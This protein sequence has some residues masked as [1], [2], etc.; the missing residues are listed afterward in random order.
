MRKADLEKLFQEN[1][2]RSLSD[3]IYEV[4]LKDIIEFHL[5]PGTKI[6]ETQLAE[7]L[8]VSKTPLRKALDQLER[9]GHVVK[10]YNKGTFVS[11]LSVSDYFDIIDFRYMIEPMAAGFASQC[12][13]EK[14]LKQLLVYTQNIEHV[15]SQR[16]NSA[17]LEAEDNFHKYIVLCSK[18]KYLID[19]YE[20]IETKIKKYRMYI[21]ADRYLHE[22]LI[23]I[24]RLIYNAIALKDREV[25][26][27]AAR[28]HIILLKAP[29]EGDIEES[30]KKTILAKI[31]TIKHLNDI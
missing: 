17:L 3:A 20:R 7:C 6:N 23:G 24:H 22:H 14:E 11:E 4:L 8:D 10:I 26:E 25:A 2:F 1:P 31:N 30:A 16:D 19:A 28:R 27:A 18:N 15:Y 5:L 29:L 13:T 21:V 12:I 9:E